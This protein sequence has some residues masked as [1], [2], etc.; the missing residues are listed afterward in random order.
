MR[1]IINERGAGC[2]EGRVVGD[3]QKGDEEQHGGKNM[4]LSGKR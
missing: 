4:F 3:Q 2:G 1:K